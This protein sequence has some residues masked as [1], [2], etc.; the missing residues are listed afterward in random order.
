MK[1]RVAAIQTKTI[2]EANEQKKNIAKAKEYVEEAATQG[3][4]LICFP[5]TYPGPW[6]SPLSYSPI[7]DLEEIASQYD[8]YLIAGANIPV[9]GN[10]QKG[11]CSEVLVGPK[12]FIGRYNRT[13]PKGPWIYKGGHFGILITKRQMNCLFLI[14]HFVR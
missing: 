8:V 14:Y 7:K 5:E 12:G 4:K 3:A 9:S 6:K 11:Y 13:T 2:L 1:I 10:P